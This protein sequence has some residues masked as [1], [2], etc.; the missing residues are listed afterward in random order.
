MGTRLSSLP[1][2]KTNFDEGLGEVP[3][4]CWNSISFMIQAGSL[5]SRGA[6]P[7]RR[8]CNSIPS[9]PAYCSITSRARGS[10]NSTAS[11]GSTFR[12]S[13]S[14]SFWLWKLNAQ[15]LETLERLRNGQN[16]TLRLRCSGIAAITDQSSGASCL[17]P[18]HGDAPL[19]VPS[20][21]CENILQYVLDYQPARWL[22]LPLESAH[23]PNWS[24]SVSQVQ[25][26][27]GFLARGETHEAL[28]K[29]LELLE[30]RQASPFNPD[31][32]KGKFDVDSNKEEALQKLISGIA[33]Y[34]N[35]VGH[36]RS[37][38]ERDASGN[39]MQ[40]PVDQY[41]AELMVAM[42]QLLVA[43]LERVPPKP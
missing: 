29:C 22:E 21:D 12:K 38:T 18:I 11:T 39:L 7:N 19:S 17:I 23:W 30:Q 4:R 36:H 43:Y 32:W 5:R 34:L 9:R 40:S 24:Q 16:L 31:V 13:H 10:G 41:E 35:K 3:L 1:L 8:G 26:A 25:E 42:T 27:V 28:R 15:E 14:P 20:S 33:V 37:R 6:C 2:Y